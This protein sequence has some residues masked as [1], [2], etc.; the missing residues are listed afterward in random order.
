MEVL[1]IKYNIFNNTKIIEIDNKLVTLY[2][3]SIHT[4][5]S[6]IL[7]GI[8]SSENAENKSEEE[9]TNIILSAMHKTVELYENTNELINLSQKNN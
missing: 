7:E 5:N 3:N 4:F 8:I 1:I 2:E 9:M 6:T